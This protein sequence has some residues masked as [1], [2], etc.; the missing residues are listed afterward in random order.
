V[1]PADYAE[2]TER[3][4][5]VQRAAVTLRWTGSWHTV[6]ITVDPDAG[7]DAASLK[8]QLP[9]FIDVY[10]MAGHD[11]EFNDPHYVSLEIGL[12]VCVKPD[13]FR[14]DVEAGLFELFSNRLLPDGRKGLFYP[15]N[16]SFGQTV[17]L[18]PL[19]AAAHS[20]AGVAS[21]QVTQFRRQGDD[22]PVPLAAGR[23]PLDR[24]EI[25]RLDNDLNFPE[26]GVLRLDL[27][28]G[29]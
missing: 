22:D 27:H 14:G 12:H 17:Y 15:D 13:Y 5:G 9:P 21:V 25:A 28:G 4:A 2:V 11:M 1:T 6:F 10:R 26:H 29:K 3:Y 7:T 8:Q 19:Y 23:L 16:F 20:V 18:S 24:L